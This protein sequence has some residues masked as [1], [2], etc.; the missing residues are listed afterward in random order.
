MRSIA[1]AMVVCLVLAA[2]G[3][4]DSGNE[5]SP[6]TTPATVLPTTTT[7]AATT[8]T[9]PTPT[10]TTQPPTTTTTISAKQIAAAEAIGDI[11]AGEQLFNTTI[12]EMPLPRACSLCHSLD[13]VDGRAPTLAGISGNAGGRVEGLSA[14]D[15]L[16]QSIA[17]PAAFKAG[18]WPAV[19]PGTYSD[20]LSEEEI[21]NLIAFL[22][23][24]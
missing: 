16:R 21:D 15:Y 24:R 23:T 18:D 11:A 6:S 9:Q 7:Q 4:E 14:V 3:G 2:C 22:L 8:T 13:G 19:M 17:D 5:A 1:P 10:T 20:V 12:D